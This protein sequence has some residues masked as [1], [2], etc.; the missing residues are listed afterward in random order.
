[1]KLNNQDTINAPK[2]LTIDNSLFSI[3]TVKKLILG[4]IHIPGG[5]TLIQNKHPRKTT[6]FL[7]LKEYSFWNTSVSIIGSLFCPITRT[8][9]VS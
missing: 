2:L 1:M 3:I 9:F 6:K 8:Q 4:K 5:Y 7:R